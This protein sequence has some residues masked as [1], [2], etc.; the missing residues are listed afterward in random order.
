MTSSPSTSPPPP[1]PHVALASPSSLPSPRRSFSPPLSAS[2]FSARPL[3]GAPVGIE[4]PKP[5]E[6]SLFSVD[7]VQLHS[8]VLKVTHAAYPWPVPYI[9][10]SIY[11]SI[12]NI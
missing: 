12:H 5:G 7:S 6:D 9:Y 8:N 10:L 11:L 2:F 3:V 1:R 4:P